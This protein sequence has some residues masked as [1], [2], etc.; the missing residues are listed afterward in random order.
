[1][2]YRPRPTT[3][4]LLIITKNNAGKAR[5]STEERTL[6]MQQPGY[7]P[8]GTYARPVFDGRRMRMPITRRTVDHGASMVRYF[9]DYRSPLRSLSSTPWTALEPKPEYSIN[10][11]LRSV[12]ALQRSH[13][14]I[15]PATDGLPE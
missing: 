11:L 9:E 4:L 13:N 6:G 5:G 2:K 7:Q 10:V 14:F 8:H 1:M 3:S 15:V 12:L